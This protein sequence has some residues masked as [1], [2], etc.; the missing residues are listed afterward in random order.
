[1]LAYASKV[2]FTATVFSD[3]FPFTANIKNILH[4]SFERPLPYTPNNLIQ[5]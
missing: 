3:H 2:S 1:M 5:L 4:P